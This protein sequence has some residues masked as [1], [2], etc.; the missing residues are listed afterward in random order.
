MTDTTLAQTVD[1]HT[2]SK[3]LADARVDEAVSIHG[4]REI[5]NQAYG[6]MS[7]ADPGTQSRGWIVRGTHP[8]VRGTAFPFEW[9]PKEIAE[10]AKG[11]DVLWRSLSD[12]RTSFYFEPVFCHGL[13]STAAVNIGAHVARLL[14]HSARESK[15][16]VSD[17]FRRL[18]SLPHGWDGYNAPPIDRE[19]LRTV[20]RF[21]DGLSESAPQP[22]VVPTMTGGVQLEWHEGRK[23]LELEFETADRIHYLRWNPSANVED[24]DFIQSNDLVGAKALLQWLV[25]EDA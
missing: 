16:V 15:Q 8:D 25:G 20:A 1:R 4:L 2:K 24:E 10:I 6:R 3:T 14:E 18:E 21:L 23:S 19:I 9:D 11:I 5:Y 17:D 13:V 7:K 12:V 22:N